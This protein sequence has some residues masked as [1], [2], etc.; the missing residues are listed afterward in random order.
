MLHQFTPPP[1]RCL[2]HYSHAVSV[3]TSSIPLSITL[4]SFCINGSA[5]LLYLL[6][7]TLQPCCIS[8]HLL[9][10]AAYNITTMQL[11][12]TPPPSRCL[13]YI[14]AMLYQCTPPPFRCLLHYSHAVSVHTSSIP[15]SITLQPCCISLHLLHPAVYCI[16]TMLDHACITTMLVHTSSIPLFLY[17]TA[18]DA[19]SVHT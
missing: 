7:I 16:T 3:H 18:T 11:Q 17:I 9:H 1:S 10:P 14:T 15:L 6:S 4:Q 2:L 5:H 12:S 19:I 8:L 13:L